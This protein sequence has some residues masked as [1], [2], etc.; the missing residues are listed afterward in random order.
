MAQIYREELDKQ[1]HK[2]LSNFAETKTLINNLK[3]EKERNNMTYELTL[4]LK[5]AGFKQTGKHS[6]LTYSR[7]EGEPYHPYLD[8]LIEACGDRFDKLELT[9]SLDGKTK[10]WEA[11]GDRYW[12]GCGSNPEEAVA[13]LWLAINK[14]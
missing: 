1:T 9:Q 14:K 2:I 7:G 12:N 10:E 8:E 5:N 11:T 6:P 3:F 13:N 4:Q